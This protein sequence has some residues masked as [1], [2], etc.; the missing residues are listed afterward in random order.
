MKTTIDSVRLLLTSAGRYSIRLARNAEDVT[1]A[2][3]LRFQV[4][5]IELNE[6]LA[7]S[8]ATGLDQDPFDDVCDHL[9]VE[10]AASH[11]IVGTYRLQTGL[12]AKQLLGYYSEQEFD[13]APYE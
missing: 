11:E 12:R 9:L 8:F 5:N 3:A 1:A 6:G 2:Q 7:E 10:E 4:F 13:F